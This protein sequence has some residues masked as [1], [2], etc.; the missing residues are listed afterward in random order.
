MV[1]FFNA[2]PPHEKRMTL[3]T[4][5]TVLRIALVP[6]LVG[7]MIMSHWNL[8]FWLLVAA[9]VTDVLDGY[10]AR[11]RNEQTYLGACLDPIADKFLLLSSF[12]TLA[13]V[14]TPL[15]PIPRWFF[16]LLLIKESIIVGG[17][18]AIYYRRGAVTIAP[19]LLGKMSTVTQL[20][21]IGWL[22]MRYFFCWTSLT[23]YYGLLALMSGV[24][25]LSFVHYVSIGIRQLI[26]KKG[27]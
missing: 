16:I 11:V 18:Y 10:L 23:I 1:N 3:S 2:I 17:A 7:A 24:T 5:L 26:Q 12:C 9:A 21:F 15:F 22:F 27:I 19:T 6:L 4:G 13:F 14:P 25:L 20:I 8:A